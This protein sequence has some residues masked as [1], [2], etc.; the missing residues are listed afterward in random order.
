MRHCLDYAVLASVLL[1]SAAGA[2]RFETDPMAEKR[3]QE[4]KAVLDRIVN[5]PMA[6]SCWASAVDDLKAGCKGMD[7]TQRSKLAVQVRGHA[8][9]F[10]RP[11]ARTRA[12]LTLSPLVRSSQTA[13]WKRAV[14]RRTSA[15]RR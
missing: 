6:S 1:A 5:D 14:W 12:P 9:Y 3:F 11:C 15:P 10:S 4:G 13:T 2:T 8:A 7:D